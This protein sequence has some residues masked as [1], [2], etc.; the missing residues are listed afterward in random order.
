MIYA[1]KEQN[2]KGGYV[3][4]NDVRYIVDW[5]HLIV[6]PHGTPEELGYEQFESLDEALTKWELTEV[7]SEN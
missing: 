6:S 2:N 1:K 7:Q 4:S 5:C 3:D